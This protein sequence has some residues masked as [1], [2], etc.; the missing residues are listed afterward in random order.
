MT[1]ARDV[2]LWCDGPGCRARHHTQI[3]PYQAYYQ[4]SPSTPE[5]RAG[6]RLDGWTT[7]CSAVSGTLDFCPKCTKRIRAGG[8]P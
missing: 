4:P 8:T 3:L 1:A 7:R 6:A 2:V 5:A